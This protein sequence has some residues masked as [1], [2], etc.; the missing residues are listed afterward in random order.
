[1]MMSALRIKSVQGMIIDDG[2]GDD[3]DGDDDDGDGDGED[4]DDDDDFFAAGGRRRS[5]TTASLTSL[6]KS[7][8]LRALQRNPIV[9][10]RAQSGPCGGLRCEG[11][12]RAKWTRRNPIVSPRAREQA[13]KGPQKRAASRN[14]LLTTHY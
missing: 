1:M 8:S 9:S 4:D 7:A 2:D 14:Y 11:P 3:D 13:A 6:R 5:S 10:A 12:K